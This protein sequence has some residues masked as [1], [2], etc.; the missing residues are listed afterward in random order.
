[1]EPVGV[2]PPRDGF[3]QQVRE[4]TKSEGA[5]LVFDEIVTGFRF[6]LGGAQEYFGVTPDLA[7]FG[8]GMANGLPIS[9][10]VGRA[11]VMKLFEEVFF[12]FTFG[13]EALSLA[14]SVATI[15]EMRENNVVEH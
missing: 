7:C 11:D 13:G 1:M 14:A 5:L 15:R 4:L 8:K 6:G 2:V 10:I 12:S 3:L 9:A